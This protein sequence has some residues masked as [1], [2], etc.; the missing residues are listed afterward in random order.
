MFWLN[1]LLAIFLHMA[2][3]TAGAAWSVYQENNSH[4]TKTVTLDASG[5]PSSRISW[6]AYLRSQTEKLAFAKTNPCP[7]TGKP[8]PSCKGYV[9]DHIKP[10]CD[11]GPDKASNMQ[12]QTL[13]AS[14][15]KDAIEHKVCACHKSGRTNCA[16]PWEKTKWPKKKNQ[17]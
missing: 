16:D 6:L 13:A 14:Y 1:G 11:G 10:L 3:M 12:W 8:V 2:P 15:K 7:S 17:K 5:N 9:I 4:V